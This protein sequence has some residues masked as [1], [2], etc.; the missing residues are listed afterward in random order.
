MRVG[1]MKTPFTL[2]R[3]G[4]DGVWLDVFS[5]WGWISPATEEAPAETARRITHHI[6]VRYVSD[7]DI[8]TGMRLLFGGRIFLIRAVTNVAEEDTWLRLFVTEDESLT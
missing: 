8:R 6:V 3:E 4:G 2:Q 1:K 5:L 7:L